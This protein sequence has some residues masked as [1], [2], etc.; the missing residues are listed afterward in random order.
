MDLTDRV[1]VPGAVLLAALVTLVALPLTACGDDGPARG[2]VELR[3]LFEV[4][5][6]DSPG[7]VAWDSARS[8]YLITTS[9]AREAS[10][11]EGSGAVAAVSAGGDR[12]ERRRFSS[13]T[14]GLR[15]DA[16]TGIAVRGDRAYVADIGRVVALDL[17]ADTGLY[18]VE[19]PEAESLKDVAP[20]PDGTIY[21]SDAGADAVFAVDGDGGEVRRLETAGSLRRPA[22][23]APTGGGAGAGGLLVA[24]ADGAI[25]RLELDGSVALLAEPREAVTLEGIQPDGRGGILFT[26]RARGT[27]ERLPPGGRTGSVE[28]ELWLEDL[29]A[30]ADFLLRDSTLA[31]PETDADRVRVYRLRWPGPDERSRGSRGGDR[32]V[33]EGVEP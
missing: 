4:D 17:R 7:S 24:G 1:A 11:R 12:V 33:T 22:G 16:P 6:L 19:V 23:L 15:L 25:L 5:S 10:S 8:R 3:L 26:D 28:P 21:A 2:D 20:G 13:S 9:T 27:L 18:A 32:A 29:R 30:P 14:P 31:L